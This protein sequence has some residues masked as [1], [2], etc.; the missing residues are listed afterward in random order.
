MRITS[1][2]PV[3]EKNIC[4]GLERRSY[5]YWQGFTARAF[6]WQ[7]G[8]GGKEKA[9]GSSRIIRYLRYSNVSANATSLTRILVANCSLERRVGP[10]PR[11]IGQSRYYQYIH[12]QSPKRLQHPLGG[13]R[14]KLK[15]VTSSVRRRYPRELVFIFV[16]WGFERQYPSWREAPVRINRSGCNTSLL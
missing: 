2:L 13:R 4:E 16:V 6:N 1:S 9:T 14:L 10:R 15:S 8:I 11:Y 5:W 3:A 7:E 12:T